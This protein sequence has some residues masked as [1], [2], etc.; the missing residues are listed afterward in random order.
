MILERKTIEH[1]VREAIEKKTTIFDPCFCR[2]LLDFGS[3]WAPPGAPKNTE[4]RPKAHPKL[5]K[6]GPDR[7]QALFS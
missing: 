3:P 2:F 1:E 6:I 4:K 7:I 5:K